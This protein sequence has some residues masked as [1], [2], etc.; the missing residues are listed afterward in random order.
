M[1]TRKPTGSSRSTTLRLVMG[2]QENKGDVSSPFG[3]LRVGLIHTPDHDTQMESR[4]QQLTELLNCLESKVE[5]LVSKSYEVLD[6][7]QLDIPTALA[8]RSSSITR[9]DITDER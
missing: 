9:K 1:Q 5:T 4:D 6:I 7:S 2:G 3:P 8:D